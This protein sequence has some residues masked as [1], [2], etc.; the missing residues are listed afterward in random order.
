MVEHVES[1]LARGGHGKAV[2]GADV[3]DDDEELVAVDV[4]E[5]RH[6][7]VVVPSMCQLGHEESISSW[8]CSDSRAARRLVV[9]LAVPFTV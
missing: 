3:L 8:G 9:R 5:E 2:T 1:A 6:V 4:P 7:N